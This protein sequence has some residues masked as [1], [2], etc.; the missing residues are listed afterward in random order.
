MHNIKP[1]DEIGYSLGVEEW[2]LTC[3]GGMMSDNLSRLK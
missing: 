3:G 1:G 2:L